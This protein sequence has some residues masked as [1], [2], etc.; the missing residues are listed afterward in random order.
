MGP[1]KD[2]V[3]PTMVRYVSGGKVS[4]LKSVLTSTW[5]QIAIL[6]TEE[7]TYISTR[8]PRASLEIEERSNIKTL[9]SRA[10]LKTGELTYISTWSQ[11]AT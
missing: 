2:P 8:S 11:R 9:F 7:L 4:K 1:L 10:S 6:N 3:Y 5:Y